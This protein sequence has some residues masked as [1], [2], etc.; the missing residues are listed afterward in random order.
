MWK[1]G[2]FCA[3]IVAACSLAGMTGC[4]G[5]KAARPPE[6]PSAAYD[7]GLNDLIGGSQDD[8]KKRLGEPTDVSRTPED[9][10]LWVYTPAWKIIP[11]DRGTVY[12]EFDQGKVVRIFKMK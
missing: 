5:S 9:R 7:R 2:R 8:V 6:K 10:I 11:N 12:V 3:I 4:G 1:I